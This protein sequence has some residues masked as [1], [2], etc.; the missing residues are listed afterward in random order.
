L[1]NQVLL[2]SGGRVLSTVLVEG[3][4]PKYEDVIPKE[5]S[6]RARLDRE[7]FFG[8]VRRAA[9]LTTEESRAVRLAFEGETL[10]ITSQ[11]A[12]YGD[13]RIELPIGYEG[14]PLV[15][16][17]NPVFVSDA[18]RAMPFDEVF[19][20]LHES[21]RPGVLSGEDKDEFLYVVMPVSLST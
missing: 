14:E 4:F 8:A 16:G 21:F 11:A 17:F 10:V 1:P 3:S 2:R 5:H 19:L 18:L 20:E 15:I 13:A 12:E 6:K 9:L 7:A